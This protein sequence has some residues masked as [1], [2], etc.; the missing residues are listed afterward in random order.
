MV[1]FLL[2]IF[3]SSFFFFSKL[4]NY[5][6]DW[7]VYC[8]NLIFCSFKSVLLLQNETSYFVHLN[9]C[10]FCKVVHPFKI[11]VGGGGGGGVRFPNTINMKA[12][13]GCS[14]IKRIF[15]PA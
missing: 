1:G 10:Y 15:F 8:G 5:D 4:S 6:I 12:V 13:N 9:P 7:F 14:I 2:H 3:D 11:S